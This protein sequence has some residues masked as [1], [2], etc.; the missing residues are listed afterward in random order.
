MRKLSLCFGGLVLSWIVLGSVSPSR[1]SHPVTPL[2]R[3][4]A[5]PTLLVALDTD[6]PVVRMGR[7]VWVL[8]ALANLTTEP[9]TLEVPETEPVQG[10][11]TGGMG[12]P[13]EHVFSGERFS[14]ITIEDEHNTVFGETVFVA[15]RGGVPPV[16]LAPC[17]SV[18]VRVELTK[19]YEV[20]TRPGTYKL[21]WR[22]YHGTVVSAPLTITVMSEQ[23][24]VM[25]TDCGDITMRFYYDEA[26]HHVHNFT[27]LVGQSFY[28][29]LT[30]HRVIPGGII[31]GG[32]PRGDGYGIRPDGKR[33]KAEFSKIPFELG[34]VAMARSPRDPDSASCQFFICLSRQPSFDGRQTAFARVV[35]NKSFETL[36]QIAAIPTG[37][38]D[39]P[40][41][42]VYIRAISLENVPARERESPSGSLGSGRPGGEPATR[43]YGRDG[44]LLAPRTSRPHRGLEPPLT[45]RPIA[46]TQPA[47]D[48][49]K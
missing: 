28:D 7:P 3:A 14:A 38:K 26:P 9:I 13:L 31:Q 22:P 37:P 46:T 32:D 8:F 5:P 33:L 24:A 27:Q 21:I 11:V 29:N 41:K 36:R 18:G 45:R 49:R 17:G 34:T 40:I 19:Y 23:Q 15:P 2:D 25:V 30:F 39:R 47:G 12:L 10:G 20:L 16:R 48:N 35:G 1:A 42:P 43:G 6:R 4:E 44:K